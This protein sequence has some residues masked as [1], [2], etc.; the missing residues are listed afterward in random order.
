MPQTRT[1]ASLLLLGLTAC[2]AGAG[3][4]VLS[5]P[6]DAMRVA[7]IARPLVETLPFRFAGRSFAFHVIGD[8]RAVGWHVAPG[9]IYV[10][11]TAARYATD[12][13]LAQLLAHALAHDLLAH[14]PS[15][16]DVS[17]SRTAMGLAAVVAVPGGIVLGG[18]VEGMTR[19]S[20][21]TLG[22]EIAA[23][24]IGLRLWLRSGRNC[25][26]W[27]ALREGQKER[28]QSWH[29]PIKDVAPPF[30]DLLVVASEECGVSPAAR[31]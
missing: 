31:P 2:S 21:Y 8:D 19:P 12:E 17:D 4:Q 26:T 9:I 1:A 3:L 14:P 11:Q 28:G 15:R 18:M 5:A 7:R 22:Q 10:S 16:T 30:D 20:D 23:E 29:E 24:R 13:A 25:A 6:D 27:I